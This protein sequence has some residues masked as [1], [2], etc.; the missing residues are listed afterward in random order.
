M[1]IKYGGRQKGTL[2]KVT[3]RLRESFTKL[4]EASIG[5]AQELF[6]KNV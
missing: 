1:G 6:D 3:A 5:R 2:N 4:F